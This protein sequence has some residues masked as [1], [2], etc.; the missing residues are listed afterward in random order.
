MRQSL[1]LAT[2]AALL[3]CG[4][5]AAAT[6][7]VA[8]VGNIRVDLYSWK[9]SAGLKRTV[10]LKR[11]GGGNPGHGGYAIR[12]TYVAGKGANRK[13][14][15]VNAEPGD[16]FGYF[17][18]HE[19]YRD[20]TDGAND[21]IA[22]KIFGKDDSPLGRGFAVTGRTLATGRPRLAAHMF[23]MSYPR[24]GTK[25]P[26]RKGVNGDD[27]R[28]T[29]VTR[30]SFRLYRLPVTIIWSFE[31]GKDYPR[32]QFKVGFGNVPGPDR[33]NFDLRGPYGVMRFDNG[34]NANVRRVIWGD[35]FHFATTGNP[36]TRGSGWNWN[37]ANKGSR[38]IA[39]IAGPYEMGLFEPVPF[40]K[41]A[42]A[43][44]YAD[45]RGDR[46]PTFNGG[47]GCAYQDQLLPCDWEW[48]YQSAQYSLP[49]N[50]NQPT[51]Y[52]KMAW[53]SSAFYGTGP[54]LKRVYDSPTTTQPLRGY[55]A[56]RS[57]DYSVCVVLGLTKPG[58]LTR[59]V[60]A[61]PKNYNCAAKP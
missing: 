37:V 41:S 51:N 1:L 17:V 12:M 58:G 11:E 27:V 21:T 56:S 44:G 43:D 22:H 7:T 50:R 16:G 24:Y 31:D 46:S 23:K 36:L 19:R 30:N 28:K 45:A 13:T 59:A 57:I 39:L 60:A 8:R 35:R 26:I 34:T 42:L 4:H 3:C 38:Y 40:R 14:V 52:K 61:R 2:I 6:H 49:T 9:D 33:V 47:S 32:I 48:P 25:K 20:F 10:A 15:I 53:G 29:P 18:S 5:A 54:S 55:P